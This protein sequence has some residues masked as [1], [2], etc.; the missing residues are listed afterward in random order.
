MLFD[1]DITILPNTVLSVLGMQ[2]AWE[3]TI[4]IMSNSSSSSSCNSSFSSFSSNKWNILGSTVDYGNFWELHPRNERFTGKHFFYGERTAS[5]LC[6][7]ANPAV[8]DGTC[9]LETNKV[10]CYPLNT[11]SSY[12][13]IPY[14]SIIKTVVSSRDVIHSYGVY[15]FGCK[16][17]AIPG[18]FNLAFSIK[19]LIKGLFKGFCFELCGTNHT[20]MIINLLSL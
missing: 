8:R 4:K 13:I 3:S 11:T 14:H 1:T 6:P 18:R 19:P 2:W 9:S 12:L 5:R 7:Y 17:D 10:I 15:S 16:I 20:S